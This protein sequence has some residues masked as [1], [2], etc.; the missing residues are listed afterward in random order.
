M[1]KSQDSC[2]STL[3]FKDS[4]AALQSCNIKSFH[5]PMNEKA[6]N[7]GQGNWLITSPSANYIFS[8]TDTDANTGATTTTRRPGCKVYIVSLPCGNELHGP[9]IHPRSDFATSATKPPRVRDIIIPAPLNYLFPT[10]PPLHALPCVVS[11]DSAKLEFLESVRMELA[12]LPEYKKRNQEA[13]DKI[14]TPIISRLATFNRQLSTRLDATVGWQTYFMCAT[15]L[16]FSFAILFLTFYLFAKNRKLWCCF[17]FR[18][19]HIGREFKTFP[20]KVMSIYVY[21]L[22]SLRI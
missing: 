21:T 2:P 11:A 16:L 22:T 19:T 13:I 17:L 10:L 9:I 14:A 15:P 3:Y 4:L 12:Q 7:V 6:V 20:R 1:E 5:L 8:Q 18:L